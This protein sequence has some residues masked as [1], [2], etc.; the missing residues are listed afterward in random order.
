[1][2][3]VSVLVGEA[4]TRLV[5]PDPQNGIRLAPRKCPSALRTQSE[6]VRLRL[7]LLCPGELRNGRAT[8]AVPLGRGC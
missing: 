8:L 6:S 3:I 5:G 2:C 7:T 1:M 4:F